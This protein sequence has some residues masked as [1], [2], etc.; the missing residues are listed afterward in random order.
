[1][2]NFNGFYL[3]L[4]PDG[5]IYFTEP[6]NSFTTTLLGTIN[7][8]NTSD[9]TV[10]S[11]VFSYENNPAF[12]NGFFSL[13]NFPSWIFYNS[14]EAQIQFGPDTVYICPGDTLLLNAGEGTS[15]SW[16]G[17]AV[18]NTSQFF[19][20]TSPGIFSATVT[21]SCGLG[22]DQVV[23]LPC[24]PNWQIS[25]SN[26]TSVCFGDNV[27][28][29]LL[30]NTGGI[31]P[32]TYE[33]SFN[34]NLVSTVQQ[35]TF[36]PTQSG[37]ACLTVTDANGDTLSEC[38]NITVNPPVNPQFSL[39]DTVLCWPK[40]FKLIN[41]TNQN[42]FTTQTWLVNNVAYSNQE[43][44][45]FNPIQPGT[46]SIKLLLT[47]SLGCEYDTL[48]SNTLLSLS[49]PDADFSVS[50][51]EVEVDN[52]LVSFT[53][54]SSGQISS[55]NWMFFVSP[56]VEI[57]TAQNPQFLFPNNTEG[58]Y[59]VQLVVSNSNG[60][61]DSLIR[62]VIVFENYTLFVPNSFSPDGNEYN[63]LFE[64]SGYG[65][66]PQT[67]LLQI[68]NRWGEL[69]FVSKDPEKGWDGSYGNTLEMAPIGT[70][71]Y[72]LNYKIKTQDQPKSISGHVNLI[73]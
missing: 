70:Y 44:F 25:I 55:W 52:P 42:T 34:G 69:I 62:T 63:N 13:P 15:W 39:L 29:A 19:T 64:V 11:G 16:G 32:F 47:N 67:F 23:V 17:D 7:C 45:I 18:S 58:N 28:P 8:P 49:S 72:N 3:Q 30:S 2:Q 57:S 36:S 73:R 71:T 65:I 1:V 35:F 24:V 59:K 33:W 60:C 4:A 20:V 50:P 68:Y 14:Y 21:S 41:E 66:N 46:Y 54:Q 10:F 56:S 12:P 40:S 22:S 37:T 61:S 27:S 5:K 38:L 43:T 9:P 48:I 53:D 31:A 51:T 6:I 26:D